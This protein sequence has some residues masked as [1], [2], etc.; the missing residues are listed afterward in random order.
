MTK[1]ICRIGDSVTGTCRVSAP[2]HPRTFTGTWNTGSGVVEC[3]G[4]GVVRENDTGTTD[5]GHT[6]KALGGVDT[7]SG[8]GLKMQRVGDAVT[9]VGGGDGVSITG[10]SSSTSE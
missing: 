7:L 2:G 3:D 9:V 4:I 5:C 10:S 6:F 1:G 8:D